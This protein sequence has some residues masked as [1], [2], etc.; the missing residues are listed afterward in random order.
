MGKIEKKIIG[1]VLTFKKINM[2]LLL[3][4][5]DQ[6]QIDF[7]ATQVICVGVHHIFMEA[8]ERADK[9]A[10]DGCTGTGVL[11]VTFSKPRVHIIA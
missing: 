10:K 3:L 9:F 8:N 7:L 5:N 6:N 4:L 11:C 2:L 1:Q